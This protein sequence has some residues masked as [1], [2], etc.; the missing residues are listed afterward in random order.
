MMNN[1]VAD[2][3]NEKYAVRDVSIYISLYVITHL[4]IIA[5]IILCFGNPKYPQTNDTISH[6][7]IEN[8]GKRAHRRCEKAK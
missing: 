3:S 7:K 5:I 8:C 4:I 1:D 2:N 6:S